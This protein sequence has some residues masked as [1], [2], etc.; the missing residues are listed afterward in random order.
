MRKFS[1]KKPAGTLTILPGN[2]SQIH[3]V[4]TSVSWF[5][6]YH[7]N[8][9]LNVLPPHNQALL[10]SSQFSTA[11]HPLCPPLYAH[12]A[13]CAYAHVQTY[14]HTH[15]RSWL[16]IKNNVWKHIRLLLSIHRA[17]VPGPHADT[18][19]HG[20]SSPLKSM[21]LYSR[22]TPTPVSV[23]LH[24]HVQRAGSTRV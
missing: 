10:P 12:T 16:Y 4:I 5:P 3:L 23:V 19:I 21:V 6:C 8:H 7:G 14:I 11:V 17:W 9:R 22:P 18:K 20:C 15:T 24:P 2:L 1:I 13:V